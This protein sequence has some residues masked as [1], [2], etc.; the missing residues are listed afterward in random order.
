MK[1]V[2]LL[3][4]IGDFVLLCAVVH[5]LRLVVMQLRRP[6]LDKQEEL[7]EEI[8]GR[9]VAVFA[10]NETAQKALTEAHGKSLADIKNLRQDISLHREE[11]RQLQHPG[12]RILPKPVGGA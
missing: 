2:I 4:Q 1:V 11:V 7:A 5:Y 3:C 8:E 12:R 10:K 9:M 6:I